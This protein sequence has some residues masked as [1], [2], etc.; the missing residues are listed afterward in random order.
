MIYSFCWTNECATK[1]KNNKITPEI[2]NVGTIK[3]LCFLKFNVTAKME[4]AIAK[5]I[6]S[7]SVSGAFM[8]AKKDTNGIVASRIGKSKQ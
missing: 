1:F 2:K 7:V 4:L 3:F 8:T 6:I 5:M